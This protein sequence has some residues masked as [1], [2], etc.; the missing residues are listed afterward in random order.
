[1]IKYIFYGIIISVFSIGM[2]NARAK[3]SA[4][5]GSAPTIL[6]ASHAYSKSNVFHLKSPNGKIDMALESGAKISW[7]VKHENTEVIVPSTISLTLASGVVLGNNAKEISAK[8]SKFNT[9][10]AT[11]IYKKKTVIDEYNQVIVKFKGDF[12]LILRAYNDGVAYRFFTTK[13]GQIIIESEEA[14]FNF[15]KDLKAFIPYV[16][17]LRE[18][19]MYSSAF[20][21]MYDEIPISKFVK[22]S[23][24]ISPLLI[25]LD[26]GKK[27]AIIE[28][29]LEDYPGMFLTRNNQTQPGLQG[30]FAH[31]PKE[32]RL[33]GYNKMNY[34]VT[35][36]ES[37]I[38]KTSGTRN[39]PW[40]AII[41]SES[42]K[43][44]LNNDM[45]QK[46]SAPSQIADVSWIKPGKVAWDWWNDWNIS[47]VDFKAGINTE[48]YKYYIDFASK[49]HIEYVVLDE[50]WSEDTN[51]L[52][53]SPTM[54]IEELVNYGKQ[55][56][57]GIILWA[58]WYAINQD[59]DNAFSQ[60]SKM[61]V[62]GFKID[63]ID[64]DDQKMVESL[65]DIAKKAASYKLFIDY[66]GMY[67]PTG[68]QR[69]YPNIVNF[70]GVKG[71]EN[72]KWTPNDDMPRYETSIP[73]IRML[74][75]AMDYTPG[76]MRNATKADFRPS[77]SMPMSQGTRC[78][79]LGMY[80]VFEAPLQMMADSPTAYMKEQESTTFISH[81]PTTFDETIALDGKVGEY[82]AI[83]RR[84]GNRWFVGGLTNWSARVMTIDLSFLNKGTYSAEIFKDGINAEK[85]A[86]D[87]KREIVEVTSA[88]KLTVNMANGGGFAIIIS[89]K[90]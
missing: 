2:I 3:S 81:I 75:G 51:L 77:N 16:R 69:T 54:N 57:V 78:H 47:K 18:N 30:A 60:Y 40:R 64:R 74:A 67:K 48:T 42:D 14:N 39:F 56:N 19:D 22:D 33:G 88:D 87:Y 66:H 52:K 6:L 80:V 34:M 31:Y 62:K 1:M 53:V 26:N 35:K 38:A 13:K 41:I 89:P 21:A 82:L 24:A 76:A 49:N 79:Q 86:T 29:E 73:F 46:L 37:Y 28:A 36:R 68:I 90:K 8:Y 55:K 25:D 50:G 59:L 70:E 58:S 63:F 85:D 71:L 11:P 4:P 10:F 61:G 44:L 32:E 7:S 83:A 72:A 84:K 17:N 20:E 27:A 43:D 65:Y 23:L 15:S 9:S 12:G 5:V 45:V